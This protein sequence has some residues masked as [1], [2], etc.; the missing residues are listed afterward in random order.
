[1]AETIKKVIEIEID[2]KTS[3]VKALNK[4]IKKTNTNLKETNKA[5][6][7]LTSQLDKMTGGAVSGFMKLAKGIKT[8]VSG[9]KVF[10]LALIGTGIGALLVAVG[11]LV[12]YFQ[13]TKRGAEQLEVAFAAVGAAIDV[14]KDRISQIGEAIIK[15]FEGDFAGAA[16]VAKNAVSGIGDEIAKE[17]EAMINLTRELQK[18]KDQERE[19]GVERAKTNQII[20]EARL[21][22]ED[23]TK[24]YQERIQALEKANKLEIDTAEKAIS[25]AQRKLDQQTIAVEQ[26]ESM[27]EDLDKLAQLE[28]QLI[29]LQTN[30]FNTRKRL[31]TGLETLR[32]EEVAAEKARIKAI[33]DAR[34]KAAKE[35]LENQKKIDA[36]KKKGDKEEAKRLKD[37]EDAKKLAAKEEEAR[38]KALITRQNLLDNIRFQIMEQGID[39]ELMANARKY[40]AL[41]AQAEGNAE[42]QNQITEKQQ[43]TDIA[44]RKKYDAQSKILAQQSIQNTAAEAQAKADIQLQYLDTIGSVISIVEMF[45]GENKKV[46]KAAILA[47]SAVGIAK[48]IISV[49]AA[50]TA[51]LAT[52]QAIASSGVSAIPVIAATVAAGAASIAGIIKAT[53]TAMKSLGGGGGGASP[54]LSGATSVA[55]GGAPQ[56]NT[57]GQSGFNQVA[58]S[59][60]NQNQG[61]IKAYVVANDVT[62]QQS[63]D[64]NSHN[65]SSF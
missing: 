57:V 41:Y 18:I 45:Q 26:S 9:L 11:A 63:L 21:I 8:G 48:T 36:A 25:L 50:S 31:S 42:L 64:R 22:A 10:K 28:I 6:A 46:Q 54:S 24:T 62:S 7:G 2:T 53:D 23:E 55:G 29:D 19:F 40:D 17:T 38:V 59:I 1:M 35:R 4:D 30:S 34:N 39:K 56:F 61:P 58:G 43:S 16:E 27:A 65:K 51:A 14:I 5:T 47:D 49:N 52:P 13:N 33:Q 32:K 3:G 44:I 37:I 12:S 15:V 20:A 60:A